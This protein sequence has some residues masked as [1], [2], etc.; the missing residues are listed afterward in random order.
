[1]IWLIRCNKWHS[2]FEH[3][4][5]SSS[6]PLLVILSSQG[7]LNDKSTHRSFAVGVWILPKTRVSHY[8]H[9]RRRLGLHLVPRSA[10]RLRWSSIWLPILY[11]PFSI[12]FNPFHTMIPYIMY[13]IYMYML[14]IYDVSWGW[15]CFL[16]FVVLGFSFS[17]LRLL[18][19]P[20]AILGRLP[21][22]QALALAT[23]WRR[24][25]R[26]GPLRPC[27]GAMVLHT[28]WKGGATGEWAV[29]CKMG[30][31]LRVD[32]VYNPM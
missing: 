15:W 17:R 29:T 10:F 6:T 4:V 19:R 8:P 27:A 23:D 30:G 31:Q 22:Q 11:K 21:R 26:P 20:Q 3:G 18:V 13:I 32:W 28:A 16:V 2:Y 9:T 12:L 7:H 5:W 24:H 1:V 14:Y 25:R